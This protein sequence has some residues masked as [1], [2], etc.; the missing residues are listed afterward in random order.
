MERSSQYQPPATT[1]ETI[2][3]QVLRDAREAR[4]LGQGE[5]ARLA[6]VTQPY[7]S[8]IEQG[9]A[10]PSI[11]VLRRASEQLDLPYTE[12][13]SRTEKVCEAARSRGVEVM[14]R[15]EIQDRDWLP[16][17]G[18]AAIGALIGFVLARRGSR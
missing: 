9:H 2:L 8:K 12:L 10:N 1:Y 16:L 17:L 11:A 13:V 7:W 18:A 15:D 14:N 5:M 6:G 4:Q 3:G